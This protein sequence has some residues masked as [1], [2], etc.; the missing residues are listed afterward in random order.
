MQ[1]IPVAG[2]VYTPVVA[3]K[4]PPRFHR[5]LPDVDHAPVMTAFAESVTFAVNAAKN[6]DDPMTVDTITFPRGLDTITPA[7]ASIAVGVSIDIVEEDV[8]LNVN[9]W[10]LPAKR[11][12]GVPLVNVC[13][14]PAAIK[15]DPDV[16]FEN[17]TE[18]HGD[19]VPVNDVP[20]PSRM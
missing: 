16:E 3:L 1:Y 19:G 10:V 17:V 13:P 15:I 8:N 20:E 12:Y 6:P 5:P 7:P 18:N 9:D 2:A 14:V 11:V 4:L